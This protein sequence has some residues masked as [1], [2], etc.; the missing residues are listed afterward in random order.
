MDSPEH[1]ASDGHSRGWR[2]G[3]LRMLRPSH[4]HSAQSAAWLM[5][6]AV[7][8]S[9]IFGFLRESYI[10]YAFGAGLKTDAFVAAFTLPDYLNY[11]LAGGAVS[12]TFV[13]IFSRYAAQDREADAQRAFS[14]V[15]TV[16][17]AVLAFGILLA[18]I[19]TRPIEHLM[20]PNF[21]PEQLRLCVSLTRIL[22]PAQLF[23]YVGGVVSAAQL[24]RRQFL[25]PA[26]TPIIYNLGIIAG[27]IFWGRSLGIS[28][29]AAGAV[30]GA[31]IGPFLLNAIGARLAGMEF[32][33]S[34]D[35]GDRGFREWLRLSIP[36]M[37]GVSLVAADD[38]ILRY[39][40]SGGA[41]DI[42]RLNYAKRLFSVPIAVLGQA[43]GQ[44]SLPF[45]SRL[46]GENKMAELAGSVNQAVY[47]MAAISFLVTAWMVACAL[48]LVDL[49]YRR[50]RFSISDSEST[51]VLFFCFAFSLAF[52]SAQALYA[53]AFYAASDMWTPMVAST[54][55]TVASL[56]VY[57]FLFKTYGVVGLAIASNTG[58]MANTVVTAILLH[59]KNLAPLSGLPWMQL[60]KALGTALVAA[61]AGTA[62]SRTITWNGSR[63]ADFESLGL[64]S[65]TW[66]AAVAAGLWA[67][68]SD[69]LQMLP[70]HRRL[71]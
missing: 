29:L 16:M 22:L 60:G 67:S 25:I 30:A 66:A 41:G 27:G 57:Y 20:F 54:L 62:V 32:A 63:I 10:A 39:F 34:F 47:R 71:S 64:V 21:A 9:R 46:F 56:P 36:L 50:G 42:T 68:N 4:Q 52:W 44:A 53:R 45:F 40:A 70:G 35:L 12:I 14:A 11:L 3:G 51:A 24:S 15:I 33:F 6:F 1:P 58:I 8:L 19:F 28:S 5:M 43:V 69:L 48:P 31:L 55:V 2:A 26:L 37:L 18:E 61:A 49:I 23:F 17:T 7:F 65:L 38:W 59:H 13:S